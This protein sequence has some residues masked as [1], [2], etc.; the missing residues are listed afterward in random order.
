[1]LHS[2]V[3]SHDVVTTDVWTTTAPA[4]AFAAD[5]ASVATDKVLGLP[6]GLA[7]LV[8]AVV[9]AGCSVRTGLATALP[10]ALLGWLFVVGFVVNRYGDV[11]AS[12]AEGWWP[13]LGLLLVAATASVLRPPHRRAARPT[14]AG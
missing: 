9:T 5:F 7:L 6:P 8:V 12:G 11:R 4:V 10:V 2:R 1:M 13:L 14:T 3:T